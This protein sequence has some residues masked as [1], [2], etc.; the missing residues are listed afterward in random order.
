MSA[1]LCAS[2]VSQW[3]TVEQSPVGKKDLPLQ[4][5]VWFL[6]SDPLNSLQYVFSNPLASKLLC[7]DVRALTVIT[8]TAS[9]RCSATPQ[10][11]TD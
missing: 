10:I 4:K 7:I 5:M 9:L 6:A 8:H 3:H 11:Y 2:V 1:R